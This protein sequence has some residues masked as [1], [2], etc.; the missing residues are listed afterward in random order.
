M[1]IL[2]AMLLVALAIISAKIITNFAGINIFGA[3]YAV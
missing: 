1:H 2:M 3:Q